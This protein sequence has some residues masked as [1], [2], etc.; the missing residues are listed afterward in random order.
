MPPP[1]IL[2]VQMIQP[3]LP[4]CMYAAA[5]AFQNALTCAAVT[6]CLVSLAP[7]GLCRGCRIM[8]CSCRRRADPM[9]SKRLRR[10]QTIRVAMHTGSAPSAKRHSDHRSGLLDST[11]SA[12]GRAVRTSCT[13]DARTAL[14]C[15]AV[16]LSAGPPQLNG[17]PAQQHRTR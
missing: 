8:Q 1:S 9:E 16:T 10:K 5:W 12:A 14:T 4:G 2:R 17:G 6:A 13:V 7:E 11:Q 3:A 15:C